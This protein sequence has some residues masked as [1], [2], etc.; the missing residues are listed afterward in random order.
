VQG[1]LISGRS[2]VLEVWD[3]CILDG[4]LDG[5]GNRRKGREAGGSHNFWRWL[6][7]QARGRRVESARSDLEWK[8][9]Q[10]RCKGKDYGAV[11]GQRKLA[12][13]HIGRWEA[14]VRR[15]VDR[16]GFRAVKCVAIGFREGQ[17]G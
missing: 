7:H 11:N 15:A 14:R 2:L 17:E 13:L 16:G 6:W 8:P 12:P 10:L 3:H 4:V 5:N 9:V 1:F